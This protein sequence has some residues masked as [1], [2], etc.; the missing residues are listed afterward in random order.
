MKTMP[1]LDSVLAMIALG[2]A[3]LAA[4]AV[5]VTWELK[6]T[7]T[8]S[9]FAPSPDTPNI[10]VGTPFRLLVS[11]DTAAAFS[12]RASTP[13]PVTGAARTGVRYQYFGTPA[14]RFALYAGADCN[15]CTPASLAS[16]NGIFVRDDFADP[17]RNPPPNVPYDGYTFY[18]DPVPEDDNYG[19]QVIFRDA[20]ASFSPDIV[21]V[22][23]S[24]PAPLVVQPDPRLPQMAESVLNITNDL[25]G[26]ALS[27]RIETVGIPTYGT[28]YL[29]TARDCSYPD[30]NSS[31][32]YDDC[33]SSGKGGLFNRFTLEGGGPGQGDFSVAT[34]AEFPVWAPAPPAAVRS[35][36]SVFGS[37]SFGGPASLPVVKASAYPI[38]VARNNGNVQAYQRYQYKGTVKTTM[39]LVADMTY[40]TLNNL[41]TPSNPNPSISDTS[42]FPGVGGITATLAI[43]DGNLV[44][45]ADMAAAGFGHR[46]CGSEGDV[47]PNDKPYAWPAGAVLGTATFNSRAPGVTS[48]TIVKAV[49]CATAGEPANSDGTVASGEPVSLAPNQTFFVVTTLQ[50]PARGKWQQAINTSTP[51]AN[52]GY[53]DAASTFRVTLDPQA[54]PEVVQQILANVETTCTDC[55]FEAD[56][57]VDI[58]PG[59]ADNPINV[60]STG[61]IPV[62]IFS[63]GNA[64]I[65]DIDIATLRLGGLGLKANKSGKPLC[66]FTDVD[67]DGA[68]DLVCHFQNDAA[69]WTDG[70]TTAVLTGQLKN[71]ASLIASDQVKLV[72]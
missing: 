48:P 68:P 5:P 9:R 53:A 37:V 1:R 41:V 52:D 26:N 21:V 42:S 13:D 18:M 50:T 65:Y 44:S 66:D 24:A 43:V 61:A 6:G 60:G 70:Q 71:G 28:S 29:L 20:S 19:W 30:F 54:P 2:L 8:V 47:G 10:P 49:R 40:R 14:L 17:D 12:T 31:F 7:I 23:A 63:G 51:P 11:Y 56:Y 33:F 55:T 59:S 15:P 45:P 39:P 25:N 62:A 67:L 4:S 57:R 34:N 69:N 22:D 72:P 35:L 64:S 46:S 27:G 58:K 3:P 32:A 36:G 38:D 16:R